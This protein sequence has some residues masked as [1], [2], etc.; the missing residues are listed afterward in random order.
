MLTIIIPIYNEEDNLILLIK[1]LVEKKELISKFEF[2]FINDG[3]TDN[4]EI[5]LFDLIEKYDLINILSFKY[6]KHEKNSGIG[7]VY[8]TGIKFA[9]ND[10]LTMI[11]SDNEDNIDDIIDAFKLID[12]CDCIIMYNK[13][14]EESRSYIRR[15][16]SIVFRTYLNIRF[17]VKILYFN[18]FGNIYNLNILKN[19]TITSSGFFALAEISIK[20]YKL[21]EKTIQYPRILGIRNAGN[22]NSLKLRSLLILLYEY[23][24][25][26]IK[27]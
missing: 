26:K 8:R 10:Y 5:L 18:A 4:S 6:L 1:S 24:R 11:A 23:Y 14:S 7:Q 20:M 12:S 13:N 16:I 9:A 17:N 21:S 27:N 22:S 19:I 15:I 3:S 2:L 25:L